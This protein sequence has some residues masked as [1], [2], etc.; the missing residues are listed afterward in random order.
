MANIAIVGYG[1]GGQA[2]ALAFARDGHDVSV[3]E[4][5][6][7]AAPTGAGF[8]LQ[9][10]GLWALRELGLD[11]DALACGAR[12]DRLFGCN[13][14]GR[15]VMDM[16][17]ADLDPV[18]HGLGLQ[19]GALFLLLHRALAGRIELRTGCEIAALDCEAG[20]L[21]DATGRTHGPFALVVVAD[22]ARSQLRRTIDPDA[23]EAPYPWGA[24]W[25]L[26]PDPDGAWTTE[27]RQR[28]GLARRMIGMLPVGQLP[29]ETD[30][31]RK[32]CFYW[33]VSPGQRAAPL[34]NDAL[35]A[36]AR[37]LWPEAGALFAAHASDVVLADAAYRDVSLRRAFRGRA[38]AIGDA[39]HA[40][41]PQ[42]GQGVNLA[43]LD[44]V[45]LA[46]AWRRHDDAARALPAFARERTAHWRIYRLI[47]RAL[48]PLFQSELDVLARVRDVLMQPVGRLPFLRSEMLH[49]LC[50]TKRGFF[51]RLPLARKRET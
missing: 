41:S 19:R 44:A 16:R 49:V 7:E 28:Y 22:G 45:A 34:A 26:L 40:M 14:Q 43:L 18:L 38:V 51:G 46:D 35:A 5:T 21:R 10:T 12:V 50:G 20:T 25:C 1:S 3:F 8:L 30:S 42:L 17:Y 13:E 6:P 9:P 29:G 36:E 47:S 23:R 39:A 37:E 32:V 24:R 33:S 2:T 31:A 15:A 4:R 48:T 27:L 11:R